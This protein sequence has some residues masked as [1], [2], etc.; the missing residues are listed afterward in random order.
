MP[1]IKSVTCCPS[2]KKPVETKEYMNTAVLGALESIL[3]T[4]NC[5]CGYYG[6]PIKLKMKDY[7]GW[8]R[9]NQDENR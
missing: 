4:I 3:P 9:G 7:E 2:C 5:S 8:L 1:K 6:L